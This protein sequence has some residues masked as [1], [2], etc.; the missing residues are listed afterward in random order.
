M[1]AGTAYST[2]KY[3]LKVAHLEMVARSLLVSQRYQ[4]SP[5]GFLDLGLVL[6]IYT[7][8]AHS[9]LAPL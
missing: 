7:G 5:L 6:G 3:W 9:G 4:T 2:V 8:K 1:S